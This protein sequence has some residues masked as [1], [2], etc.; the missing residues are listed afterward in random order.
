MTDQI[1]SGKL[2]AIDTSPINKTNQIGVND[3]LPE[4]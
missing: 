4:N 2:D 3:S 1:V